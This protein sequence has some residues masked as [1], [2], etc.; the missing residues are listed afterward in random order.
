MKPAASRMKAAVKA[1]A[2]DWITA[3]LAATAVA[4]FIFALARAASAAPAG[5]G[6][7]TDESVC[8][9]IERAETRLDRRLGEIAGEFGYYIEDLERVF[10]RELESLEKEV[11]EVVEGYESGGT[12]RDFDHKLKSLEVRL[13]QLAKRIDKMATAA[14][15]SRSKR[16]S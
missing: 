4:L 5:D 7:D 3:V 1:H 14:V 11:F 12:R 10:E 2:L 8:S 6:I 15:L 16:P 13:D 9:R